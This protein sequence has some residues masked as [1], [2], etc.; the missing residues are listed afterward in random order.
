MSISRQIFD[1]ESLYNEYLNKYNTLESWG[2]YETY[3]I[4]ESID[5]DFENEVC[6]EIL[7]PFTHWIKAHPFVDNLYDDFINF[8]NFLKNQIPVISRDLQRFYITIN[9]PI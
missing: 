9:K 1:P 4:Y 5:N 6:I 8:I 7:H 2:D 3:D